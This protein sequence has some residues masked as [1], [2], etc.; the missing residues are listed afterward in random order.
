MQPIISY[1]ASYPYTFVSYLYSCIIL[2][3]Y[4]VAMIWMHSSVV[5]SSTCA[6]LMKIVTGNNP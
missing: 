6:L 5:L 4:V 3:P 2:Q 1:R